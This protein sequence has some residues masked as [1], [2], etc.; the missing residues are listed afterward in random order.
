MS[1]AALS[2]DAAQSSSINEVRVA[3]INGLGLALLVVLVLINGLSPSTETRSCDDHRLGSL[4]PGSALA[5]GILI[6]LAAAWLILEDGR[7][8]GAAGLPAASSRRG[9]RRLAVA[10]L[11]RCL[12]PV[13]SPLV[14]RFL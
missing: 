2:V 10:R 5:G 14:A 11:W 4:H 8:L 3:V 12:G 13:A 7:I 6:G 9:G 1:E